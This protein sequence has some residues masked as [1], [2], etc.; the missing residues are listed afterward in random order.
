MIV[1]SKRKQRGQC[2]TC[3]AHR[4]LKYPHRTMCCRYACQNAAAAQRRARLADGGADDAVVPAF[5]YKINSVLGKRF[6]DPDQLIA[7]KRRNKLAT[8]DKAL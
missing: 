2:A 5:C 4:L 7:K 8:A 3:G 6:C 1:G